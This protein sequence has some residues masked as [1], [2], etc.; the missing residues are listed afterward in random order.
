MESR[1][2]SKNAELVRNLK[3]EIETSLAESHRALEASSERI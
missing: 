3:S 2:D 1:V